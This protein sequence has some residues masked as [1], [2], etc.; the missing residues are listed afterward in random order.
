MR[1][2]GPDGSQY[3]DRTYG[4]NSSKIT[5]SPPVGTSQLT[6]YIYDYGQNSYS[7]SQNI[8]SV[9]ITNKPVNVAPVN[10]QTTNSNG[11]INGVCFTQTFNNPV[12]NPVNAG[13]TLDGPDTARAD[14]LG[15]LSG[16]SA[17][18]FLTVDPFGS[19]SDPVTVTVQSTTC[20]YISG[21]S[22][23]NGDPTTNPAT[24]MIYN[25]GYYRAP[26]NDIGLYVSVN[27]SQ[28]IPSACDVILNATGGG[29]S[30]T[31][32]LEINPNAFNPNYKEL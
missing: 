13:F 10:T 16:K 24:T 2:K 27:F 5:A 19:F 29:Q 30:A 15:G 26:S 1:V 22:F 20:S 17:P 7:S 25:S 32:T 28:S 9:N 31:H 14:F 11:C 3:Y 18:V 21:Y 6:L 4:V 12:N 8:V 23:D